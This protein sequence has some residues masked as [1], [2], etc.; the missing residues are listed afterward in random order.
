M[1]A[2]VF[3]KILLFQ[4]F[5]Y[6]LCGWKSNVLNKIKKEYSFDFQLNYLNYF[7]VYSYFDIISQRLCNFARFSIFCCIFCCYQNS[8]LHQAGPIVY[9]IWCTIRSVL[10]RICWIGS[11]VF[12]APCEENAVQRLFAISQCCI[13]HNLVFKLISNYMQKCV[14]A[15]DRGKDKRMF[16]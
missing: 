10:F 9:R 11:P 3:L 16:C 7:V 4:C 12:H 1:R 15:K 14:P 2:G 8:I 6:L 5:P 13:Q